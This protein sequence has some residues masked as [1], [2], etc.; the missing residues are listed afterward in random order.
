MSPRTASTPLV[1]QR[2]TPAQLLAGAVIA[3]G[4][5][6]VAACAGDQE[7]VS[8]PGSTGVGAGA[9]AGD[10]VDASVV[11][12]LKVCELVDLQPLVTT[13]SSPG[14]VYGPE[15]IPPGSGVEPAG[16]QCFT[17]LD[18]PGSMEPIPARLNVA[19]VPLGSSD[20]ASEKY[21]SR[22]AEA[23][24]FEGATAEDLTGPWSRGAV[25]TAGGMTENVVMT[26]VQQDNLVVKFY[27]QVSSDESNGERFPFTLDDVTS[28]VAEMTEPL[29]TAVNA[30]VDPQ[31]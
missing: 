3:A 4:L 29:Y 7:P 5:L 6:A 22:L 8:S 27:L 25:V 24:G 17:Q 14:H 19:V 9:S 23:T 28:T 26:I 10:G 15:D 20:E 21:D 1:P 13:L 12:A 11:A 30:A 2:R 16:P 31:G 18:L